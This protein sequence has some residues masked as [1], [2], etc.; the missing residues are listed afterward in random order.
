MNKPTESSPPNQSVLLEAELDKLFVFQDKHLPKEKRAILIDEI[1]KLN[2]PFGAVMAGLRSLMTDDLVSIKF[3][4]I[5]AAIRQ[6][7]VPDEDAVIECDDCLSGYVVMK[8]AQGRSFSLACRCLTGNVKAVAQG[9]TRW[10]GEDVQM[11][12]SRILTK[13]YQ[14]KN[15]RVP[16]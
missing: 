16:F 15:D 3:P 8:D 12:K 10:S 1:S 13:P 5:I 7:M 9:L 4:T 6:K 14:E 11:S 2:F